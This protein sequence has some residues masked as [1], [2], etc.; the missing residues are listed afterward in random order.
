MKKN[1]TNSNGADNLRHEL[2]STLISEA[3]NSAVSDGE[4]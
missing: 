4:K 3:R 1:N 2:E